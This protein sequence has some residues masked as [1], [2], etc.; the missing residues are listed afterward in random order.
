MHVWAVRRNEQGEHSLKKEHYAV[1]EVK[2]IAWGPEGKRI[3]FAGKGQPGQS[4]KCVDW[5]SGN[6]FGKMGSGSTKPVLTIAFKPS[7]PYAIC[8]GAE[9][10]RVLQFTGPPFQYNKAVSGTHS[11]VSPLKLGLLFT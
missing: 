11:R 8:T 7:R 4:Q 10:Q 2:D 5:A 1:A 9:D 6:A 3:A